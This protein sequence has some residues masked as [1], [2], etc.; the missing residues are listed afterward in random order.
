M[1]RIYKVNLNKNT[2]LT[3][4]KLVATGK[5]INARLVFD[6]GAALTQFSNRIIESLGY[7]ARDGVQEVTV[8]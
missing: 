7:S 8:S 1:K 3:S 6:T 4:A 2:P 5:P